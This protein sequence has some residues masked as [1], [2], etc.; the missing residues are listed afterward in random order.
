MQPPATHPTTGHPV[1]IFHRTSNG[2]IEGVEPSDVYDF[3]DIIQAGTVEQVRGMFARILRD[4]RVPATQAAQ[5]LRCKRTQYF[6]DLKVPFPGLNPDPIEARPATRKK[7]D[8]TRVRIAK[9][10]PEAGANPTGGEV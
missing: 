1:N 2:Q 8:P 6:V 10:R 7:A 5:I 9:A 4:A 3:M